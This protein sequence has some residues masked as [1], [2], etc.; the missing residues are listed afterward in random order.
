MFEYLRACLGRCEF[1]EWFIKLIPILL[2]NKILFENS[3]L[4]KGKSSMI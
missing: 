2:S 1:Q 3:F 4:K